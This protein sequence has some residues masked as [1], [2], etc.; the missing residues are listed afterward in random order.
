M[1]LSR[2]TVLLAGCVHVHL[3]RNNTGGELASQVHPALFTSYPLLLKC[4]CQACPCGPAERT[5][6]Y[7]HQPVGILLAALL[8][9]Q[10]QL[11]STQPHK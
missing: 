10:P 5:C 1:L 4:N 3:C 11:Q 9:L 6:W 8:S 2:Q 7:M